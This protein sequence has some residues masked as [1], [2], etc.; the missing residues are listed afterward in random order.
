MDVTRRRFLIAASL[1]A[2]SMVTIS[3]WAE[4]ATWAVVAPPPAGSAV[5]PFA[6][7][8]KLG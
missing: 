3:A 1:T 8:A 5:F 7:P 6:L 2:P 4:G